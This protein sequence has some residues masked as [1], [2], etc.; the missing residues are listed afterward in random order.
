MKIIEVEEMK[1]YIKEADKNVN[2]MFV[3]DT[4]I[5][6]TT[7]VEKYAKENGYYLKTLVLSQ[8][9]ASDALGIPVK[10]VK[11]FNGVEHN[12]IEQAVPSWVFEL[13]T[14]K[15][16]ILFLDEFLAAEPGI[17]KPFLNLLT[18]KNIDGIDLSHVIVIAATNWS[19]YSFEPDENVVSRF[20]FFYVENNSFRKYINEKRYTIDYKDTMKESTLQTDFAQ[21]RYIA[22]RNAEAL[23][24]ISI[25]YLDD[26]YEA[27]TNKKLF[28]VLSNDFK[29][30]EIL[31]SFYDFNEDDWIDGHEKP[32]AV[33]IRT[34]YPRVK[35]WSTFLDNNLIVDYSVNLV[36][37]LENTDLDR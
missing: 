29:F 31:K 32:L 2:L 13:A 30:N 23:T 6:K 4:G 21:P 19:R 25:K 34:N 17:V 37:E 35:N 7:S 26:F 24:K 8:L 3:S 16:A 28:K 20:A 27:F 1:N 14:H 5:G 10:T 22:P 36:E 18:Q 12:V 11:E 15:K 9:D 33:M